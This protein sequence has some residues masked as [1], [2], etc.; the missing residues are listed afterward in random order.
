MVTRGDD[1][2]SSDLLSSC[3]AA[4][5]WKGGVTQHHRQ[6]TCGIYIFTELPSINPSHCSLQCSLLL[7]C[8]SLTG[9]HSPASSIRTPLAVKRGTNTPAP[10]EA[11]RTSATINGQENCL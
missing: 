3:A 9:F 4:G 7:C 2:R 5:H 8:V 11:A 6:P 10:R 1:P